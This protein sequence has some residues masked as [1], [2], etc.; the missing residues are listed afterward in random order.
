MQ[1]TFRYDTADGRWPDLVQEGPHELAQELA[2]LG[3]L[4]RARDPHRHGSVVGVLLGVVG[5]LE[6]RRC[7]T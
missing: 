4:V 3:Q 5:P 1:L 2:S 6:S 7:R